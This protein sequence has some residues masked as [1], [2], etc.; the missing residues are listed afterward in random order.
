MQGVVLDS[1][2]CSILIA[3]VNRHHPPCFLPNMFCALSATTAQHHNLGLSL[4]CRSQRQQPASPVIKKSH[5]TPSG[6]MSKPLNPELCCVSCRVMCVQQA[7][8]GRQVRHPA[9]SPALG[10]NSPAL[11]DWQHHPAAT[12]QQQQ[13]VPGHPHP[14]WHTERRQQ[15][16]RQHVPGLGHWV[17]VWAVLRP[18]GP[19][20]V[21]LVPLEV[22]PLEPRQ[23]VCM[24]LVGTGLVG[25]GKQGT[26][27]PSR[28]LGHI[29][30]LMFL[31]AKIRNQLRCQ[32][33]IRKR[34]CGRVVVC[35]TSCT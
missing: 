24:A 4:L 20:W 28:W 25:Q 18:T 5:F 32:G 21:A 31:S 6:S 29:P 26:S 8:S 7:T 9:S 34:A 13:E 15:Q 30:S 19:P 22:E 11:G 10:S 2:W 35:T 3:G 16:Q 14:P 17:L 1:G 12:Q 33:K 23:Q 27:S